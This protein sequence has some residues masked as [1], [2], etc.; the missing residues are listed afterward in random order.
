MF[1]ADLA[2]SITTL[3]NCLSDLRCRQD[4]LE[5]IQEVVD[6]HWQLAADRSAVFN[7][8]LA[9]SLSNPSLSLCHTSDVGSL[10]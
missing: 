8:D 7:A 6:L 10:H 2:R 9:I 1:N 5:A 3:S 4:A